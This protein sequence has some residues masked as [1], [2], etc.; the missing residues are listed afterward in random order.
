MAIIYNL[1]KFIELLLKMKRGIFFPITEE[2]LKNVRKDPQRAVQP[3]IYSNHKWAIIFYSVMLLFLI[4]MFILG[5]TIEEITWSYYLMLFLPLSYFH[6]LF[7]MFAIVDEGILY[8]S[9]FIAWKTLKSF[10][11]LPIDVNHKFYGHSR[12]VNNN[13]YELVF[14]KRFLTISL[15]VT[16]GRYE[17]ED[18]ENIKRLYTV[19]R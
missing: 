16:S 14:K 3:P 1:Y 6:N 19:K 18:N 4:V 17:G 2:E 8:G 7:N 9:R 10:H 12:E 13:G 11:I 15:I 5:T